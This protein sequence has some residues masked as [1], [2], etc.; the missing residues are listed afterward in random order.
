M[1][2][3]MPTSVKKNNNKKQ[4]TAECQ[5]YVI[6]IAPHMDLNTKHVLLSK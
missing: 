3:K 6:H 2:V 1:K 4:L 5:I